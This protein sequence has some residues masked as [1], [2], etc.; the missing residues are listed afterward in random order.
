MSDEIVA[1]HKS[2]LT[3]LGNSVRA[4]TGGSEEMALDV[5]KSKVDGLD[6]T[7]IVSNSSSNV[8]HIVRESGITAINKSN[9]IMTPQSAVGTNLTPFSNMQ[10]DYRVVI[11]FK[12]TG[13]SSG[14]RGVASSVA[15]DTGYTYIP[16]FTIKGGDTT[17]HFLYGAGEVVFSH[18]SDTTNWYIVVMRYDAVNGLH[19]CSLYSE[20]GELIESQSIKESVSTSSSGIAIGGWRGNSGDLFYGDFDLGC[21]AII[22]DGN[23]VWGQLPE[24]FANIGIEDI[25]YTDPTQFQKCEYI[26][27]TGSQYFVSDYYMTPNSRIVADMQFT[28]RTYQGRVFGCATNSNNYST[29]NLYIN[30]SGYWATAH[31]DGTGDWTSTNVYADTNRHTFD[32]YANRYI[33]IDNG[34]VVDKTFA[35]ATTHNSETV[36]D[37]LHNHEPSSVTAKGKVWSIQASEND[38][39]VRDYQPAYNIYTGEAGLFDYVNNTFLRNA[40]TGVFTKGADI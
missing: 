27:G 18:T 24:R 38:V 14:N 13:G 19:I 30:G 3:A 35:N 17:Y 7:A 23:I 33:K 4:K 20:N 28:E 16:S 36:I 22:I 32:F 25:D 5:M 39:V 8:K 31:K 26:Q 1:I 11:K 34:S 15:Y 9:M 21:S 2:K 12:H 37:F 6:T 40:G 29:Y 10:T